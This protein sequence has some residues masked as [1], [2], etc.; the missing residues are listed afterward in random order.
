MR[1]TVTDRDQ[2]VRRLAATPMNAGALCETLSICAARSARAMART[3]WVAL[4]FVLFSGCG[5]PQD[6]PQASDVPWWAESDEASSSRQARWEHRSQY[7]TMRDGVRIAVDVYLPKDLAPGTRIATI[8]EQTRYW[9]AARLRWPAE[10]L[11]GERAMS[12]R[13]VEP[14]VAAGYARVVTDVRGAGASFGDRSQ[15]WSQEEVRDGSEILDWIVRQPWS[16]GA[17]GA[18]GVSYNGAAAELLVRERHP[19]LQAVATLFA[20]HDAYEDITFPGGVQL[21][22]FTEQWGRNVRLLDRNDVGSLLDW[23]LRLAAPSVRPVHGDD[24]RTLLAAAL[25]DHERNYDV[26]ATVSSVEFRDDRTALGWAI[27]EVGPAAYRADIDANEVPIYSYSGWFDGAYARAAIERFLIRRNPRDRLTIGPWNHGGLQNASPWSRSAA[28]Q[29]PHMQEMVRFF[30]YHLRGIDRGF[31]AEKPIHY[32]TMGEEQWKAADRWP[33]PGTFPRTLFLASRNALVSE[34]PT[35]AGSDAYAIDLAAGSGT[36]TR[37][38]SLVGGRPVRYTARD[39]ADRRLLVYETD[40]LAEEA[41]VTG[42]PQVRL[43][44][45]ANTEDAAVFVYLEDVD[46][47]GVVRYVT[48]GQL[49]TLHRKAAMREAP[50]EASRLERTFARADALQLRPGAIAELRF[51][52]LPVSYLFRRGHRIRVA[53]AG[54]DTDN[55]RQISRAGTVLRLERSAQAP[56]CIVL[57]LARR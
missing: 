2:R 26:H 56:S 21:T 35:V 16:D 23:K 30:D 38:S 6:S 28:A 1:M 42:A 50:S 57:P 49:R 39:E 33:I 4:A 8:L 18:I 13:L 22:G 7:V 24:E 10:L 32:F 20:L 14:F 47:A 19:A 27:G 29:F 37:W 11:T 44:V 5:N 3:R 12:P 31:A 55:F 36:Q 45:S 34:A 17:V 51:D 41:E 53:I 43:H 40:A 9:R 52:L 48:E 15:E 54:A 25:R 46:A